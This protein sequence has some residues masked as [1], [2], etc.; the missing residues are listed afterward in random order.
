M[1]AVLV[2]AG[3]V[4]ADNPLLTCR[5]AGG[6]NPF[7]VVL[8]SRLRISPSAQLLRL[9]DADRTIIAT[10]QQAPLGKIATLEKLGILI[11]RLPSRNGRVAWLPLLRKL[12][13]I[14][15]V[16]LLIEGG[17]EIAASALKTKIVDKLALFYA[18]KIVG[19]DGRAMI[20]PLGIRKMSDALS[21]RRFNVQRHG[22]DILLWGDL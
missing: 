4:R 14:G 9:P 20:G 11:W 17:A 18:P 7:R 5:I 21:L 12:A 16:S 15:V 19:G 3:T 2:G 22:E 10:T 8:D 6:R 1:D 13:S